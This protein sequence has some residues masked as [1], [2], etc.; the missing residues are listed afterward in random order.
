MIP[1]LVI[2]SGDKRCSHMSA[3]IQGDSGFDFLVKNDSKLVD[4]PSGLWLI[5]SI[6]FP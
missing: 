4:C 3:R 6:T 5:Q 1:G 2:G